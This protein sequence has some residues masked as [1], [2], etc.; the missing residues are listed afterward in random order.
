MVVIENPS[1]LPPNKR[2][3]DLMSA[4]PVAPGKHA[5]SLHRATVAP[6][7]RWRRWLGVVLAAF[8]VL[9][10]YVWFV[11]IGTWTTWRSGGSYYDQLATAFRDGHLWLERSPSPELLALPNPYDPAARADVNF[12]PDASLYNGRYYL[13][14]G[15]F[16]AV[17]IVPIKLVL[18]ILIGDQLM[19]FAFTFGVFLVMAAALV[20]VW[21]R[22][23]PLLSLWFVTPAVLAVGLMAPFAWILGSR[24][25]V[26][27]AAISA[28][29]LFFL[30][31]IYVAWTALDRDRVS[32][33]L[34]VLAGV[35]W[36]A[37][38]ASRITQIVAV[39]VMLL[40]V[41][42][43]LARLSGGRSGSGPLLK[44]LPFSA[45]VAAGLGALAW[46]NWARFGS[47]FETGISYQLALL[48][49][50]AHRDELFSLHYVIQNLYNY[51][52]MP[53][54]LRLNFP[55][56][57][58]QLGVRHPVLAGLS[59]PPLYFAEEVTGL[60]FTSPFLVGAL[61]G[62]LAGPALSPANRTP[63]GQTPSLA[64]WL[65]T[66]LAA[67]FLSE[68]AL[69]LTFFWGSE[70]YLMDFLPAAL[71]LAVIGSWSAIVALKSLPWAR[72]GITLLLL[73]LTVASVVA[74]LLLAIAQNADALRPLDPVLW[75][76]LNNVFR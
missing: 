66:A 54:K 53:P 45:P 60:L 12:L 59:L 39:G 21:R 63:D 26:H 2:Q 19:A 8:V 17:L 24:A 25:S 75:Q 52:L 62:V 9:A 34:G 30:L 1:N 4:N 56:V 49:I 69:F 15:P 31:G 33:Q 28:G 5:Q 3:P 71:L 74:G 47:V 6:A 36:A 22:F 46:Y 76:Q 32:K 51:V 48:Y 13:Y 11:S 65:K 44:W 20:R 35:F 10:I 29:Q 57:W 40:V 50:Q 61:G 14:F 43:G 37:S 41:Y 72:A 70:R 7:G 38:L 55:Y 64:S 27:D 16:P 58:P 68:F 42:A 18:P 23:F 73:G 67:S